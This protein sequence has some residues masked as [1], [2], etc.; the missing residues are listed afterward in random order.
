[1]QLRNEGLRNRRVLLVADPRSGRRQQLVRSPGGALALEAASLCEAFPMAEES[2]PAV[3]AVSADFLA[4]PELEG[5]LRLADMLGS[6]VF[7]YSADGRAPARGTLGAQLPCVPLRAGDTILDL[8][9]RIGDARAGAGAGSGDLRAPDLVLIGASTGGISA[10]ETVLMSYP[11]ECPPTLIVQHIRDGFVQGLVRRLNSACRPRVVEAVDGARLSRGTVYFA[12]DPNRHLTVGS[13]T[14]PRCTLVSAPPRHGHRP[15]VDPLFESALGWGERVSAALLT[16]MGTDGA[17]G[18][19]VL[20]RAGAHTIA[21]DRDSS[22]V[23][24]MPRAAVEAGAAEEVLSI[25]RIGA[26]LLAPRSRPG[27]DPVRGGA[28]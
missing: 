20:R 9:D 19:A 3:M 5:L 12:A 7:L 16:G 26:A 8:V 22:V 18:L 4:E 21:Q 6:R 27:D 25:N 2:S 17:A 23:W 11:A 28:R 15:A 13:P 10:V 1:M 24:G 14:A